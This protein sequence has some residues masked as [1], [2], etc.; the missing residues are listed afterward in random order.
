V[1]SRQQGALISAQSFS[2]ART[3]AIFSPR[4]RE[5]TDCDLFAYTNQLEGSACP[6]ESELV[7]MP[8]PSS[9][10]SQLQSDWLQFHDLDRA[11]AVAAIRRSGTSIRQIARGLGFS[12]SNLRRLLETLQASPE[13]Q[14]FARHHEI[15]TNE[16]IRRGQAAK[17]R[18]EEQQRETLELRRADSARKG[19]NQIC[20]WLPQAQLNKPSCEQIINEVRRTL[21]EFDLAGLKPPPLP[22]RFRK[23]SVAQIIELSRPDKHKNVMPVD[24]M[25]IDAFYVKWLLIWVCAAF[26]DAQVRDEV[27]DL[28]L[29]RQERR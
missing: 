8:E 6:T 10:I 29:E 2:P 17:A 26:R 13:D 7:L 11:R 16:L 24:E 25:P 3:A 4:L 19:A 18:L 21:H 9:P 12:E 22:A 14:D 15:S 23:S 27:L 1:R 5:I 28:A 20:N